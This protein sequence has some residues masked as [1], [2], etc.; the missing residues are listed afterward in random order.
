MD[1][2]QVEGAVLMGNEEFKELLKWIG[3]DRS[4]VAVHDVLIAQVLQTQ[5]EIMAEVKELRPL[6]KTDMIEVVANCRSLQEAKRNEVATQALQKQISGS[7]KSPANDS[8][9]SKNI[10]SFIFSN[11]PVVIATSV[12]YIV[13][14]IIGAGVAGATIS[15]FIQKGG[16]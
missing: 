5:K 4:K 7:E 15:E 13:A 3:E 16:N 14:A 6:I 2:E 10:V 9:S 1:T 12:K 11:L 8:D